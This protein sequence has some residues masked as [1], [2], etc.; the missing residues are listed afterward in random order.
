MSQ[1]HHRYEQQSLGGTWYSYSFIGSVR[2]HVPAV[3]VFTEFGDRDHVLIV[4][5]I[6]GTYAVMSDNDT[7]RAIA[8]EIS[9]LLDIFDENM[10]RS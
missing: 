8:G 3:I 2:T 5:L 4:R 9:E 7:V 1:I 6:E 10:H